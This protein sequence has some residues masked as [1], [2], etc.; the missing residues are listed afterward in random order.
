MWVLPL[1]L[2]NVAG[3]IIIG[4][5]A[6][7]KQTNET[8]EHK[9]KHILTVAALV[10]ASFAAR[11]DS[12]YFSSGAVTNS[13]NVT[14]TIHGPTNLLCWVQ[15]YSRPSSSWGLG[16]NRYGGCS[17]LPVRSPG[18]IT[19]CTIDRMID[20]AGDYRIY[21][22]TNSVWQTS[23]TNTVVPL[24]LAE[25]FWLEKPTNTNFTWTVTVPIW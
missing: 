16:T 11:A 5:A 19:E 1:G 10:V 24:E 22:L 4:S 25:G 12:L 9:M 15:H 17:L 6:R 20:T 14:L 3:E 7:S 8:R 13:T 21:V 18:W 23:G 2:A